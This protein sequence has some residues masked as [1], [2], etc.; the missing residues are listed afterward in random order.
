ML[1]VTVAVRKQVAAAWFGIS[2][3]AAVDF[4]GSLYHSLSPVD[5]LAMVLTPLMWVAIASA[6]GIV[7][8]RCDVQVSAF[9]DQEKTSAARL[10]QEHARWL[11]Q[12]EWVSE[13]ERVAKPLLIKIAASNMDATDRTSCLLL[14]D[15]LRDQVR[16]RALATPAVLKAA[17]AARARG[18]TVEICDDREADLPPAVLLEASAQLINALDRADGGVIT[19]RALPPGQGVAVTI[20][21]ADELMPDQEFY[22]EV[23]ETPDQ[24]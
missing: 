3:F 16:G 11:S 20:L 12:N 1:M 22:L 21:A 18:A 14:Q 2:V 8:D 4:S 17:R 9:K 23:R 7:F 13:L 15:E 5:G 10:A 6:V 24:V 19:A